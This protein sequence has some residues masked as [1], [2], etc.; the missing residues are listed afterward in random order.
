MINLKKAPSFKLPSTNKD[1]YSLKNSLG[2]YVVIY[3]YPKDDTPGCTI[4]TNDFNKLLPK[5]KKLNCDVF[6]ISKDNLK[7]HDKFRYKYKIKFDLLSDEDLT[8]LK[9]YQVWAKKKFMGREF[10]GILRTTFLIDPKGKI[11]KIWEN[12]KV[13]DHAK[14]VLDTL[15][16][17]QK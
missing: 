5:F 13:K 1:Q 2:K 9:K 8:V 4:E 15:N 17:I 10:M 7:S 6:G 11:I 14:D 12:V 3:F 16:S